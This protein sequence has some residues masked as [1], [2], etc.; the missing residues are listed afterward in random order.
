MNIGISSD[1]VVEWRKRLEDACIEWTQIDNKKIGRPGVVV[2]IDESL[3]VKAKKASN[4]QGRPTKQFWMFGGIERHGV[5]SR[6]FLVPLVDFDPPDKDGFADVRAQRRDSATLI[7][8][9][10]EYIAPGSII[11]SDM[12]GGY[13]GLNELEGKPFEHYAINHNEHFVDVDRPWCHTNNIERL[14]RSVKEQSKRPGMRPH[15]LHHYM[16]RYTILSK[17][18]KRLENKKNSFAMVKAWEE[19][20]M[21]R[22]L[23]TLATLHHPN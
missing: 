8:Y 17:G 4:M 21:H 7:G 14:W 18:K 13:M 5:D 10:K 12:W 22:F 9:I 20:K 11:I 6:H 16:A 1:T 2:E 23:Q 3:C 15:R 19:R